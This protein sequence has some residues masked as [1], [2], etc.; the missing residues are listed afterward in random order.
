MVE[1]AIPGERPF[2]LTL[3]VESGAVLYAEVSR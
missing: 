1:P 2:E 3:A